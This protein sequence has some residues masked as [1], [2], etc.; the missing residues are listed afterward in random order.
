MKPTA[1]ILAGGA[2]RR[3]GAPKALADWG[4]KPM[5]AA[6]ARALAPA[7]GETLVVAK[8]ADALR[9]LEDEGVRLVPDLFAERHAL[10]GL[11]TG[12]LQARAEFC[13]VCAC[14]MPLVRAEAVAR[15]WRLSAD[16][17]AVVP[18]WRGEPQ[19]LCALVRRDAAPALRRRINRG[20]FGLT[21]AF[22]A[23]DTR[24]VPAEEID[25]TGRSFRDLD[26]PAEYA[27]A[28]RGTMMGK[29]AC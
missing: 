11:Y 23:L 2:S 9:F 3:F 16:R 21:P 12:L 24:F 29:A 5:V 15:L 27:E 1:V 13:F 6:V 14:D 19:P 25:P 26:T 20:R 7:V 8:D 22:A 17:Q 4:G 10:G 18:I 28:L